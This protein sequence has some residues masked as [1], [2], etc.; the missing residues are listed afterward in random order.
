MGTYSLVGCLFPIFCLVPFQGV[1][2]APPPP[3]E[4]GEEPPPPQGMSVSLP[5]YKSIR[6]LVNTQL[7][8]QIHFKI[9]MRPTYHTLLPLTY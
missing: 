9:Q 7:T 3:Q 2:E 6:P 5:H 1:A 8:L 4:R